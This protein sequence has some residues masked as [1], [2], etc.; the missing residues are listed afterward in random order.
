MILSHDWLKE[1]NI[2]KPDVKF[3]ETSTEYLKIDVTNQ[4]TESRTHSPKTER[5]QR[6][7]QR[8]QRPPASWPSPEVP[9]DW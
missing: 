2:L 6:P 3:C 9:G 8:S 5:G 1:N 7:P 4:K